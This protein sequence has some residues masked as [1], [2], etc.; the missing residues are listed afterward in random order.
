[1]RRLLI[2][3]SE[4]LLFYLARF[5]TEQEEGIPSLLLGGANPA[6][7]PGAKNPPLG[8]PGPPCPIVLSKDVGLFQ[9]PPGSAQEPEA[10]PPRVRRLQPAPPVPCQRSTYRW[11]L[12][13]HGLLDNPRVNC[14]TTEPRGKSGLTRLPA[15]AEAPEEIEGRPKGGVVS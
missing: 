3:G 13:N 14:I 2:V 11:Q 5:L 8:D 6:R 12:C 15:E 4:T 10:L 7:R 1:M 9:P